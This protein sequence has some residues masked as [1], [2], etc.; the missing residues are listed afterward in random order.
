MF[1]VYVEGYYKIYFYEMYCCKFYRDIFENV[2][3]ILVFVLGSLKERIFI[4]F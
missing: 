4:R 1:L 2:V 3:Y